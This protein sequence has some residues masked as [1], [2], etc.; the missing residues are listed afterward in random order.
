VVDLGGGTGGL[1]VELALQGAEVT[2]IDPSPDALAAL[3]RRAAEKGVTRGVHA[4]Q[5]DAECLSDLVRPASIDLVM[6]HRTLA[7]GGD[8]ARVLEAV[9][10]SLAPM[11]ALSLVAPQLSG[12]LLAHVVAG[13]PAR[14][15][16][17]LEGGDP[18]HYFELP[19][20]TAL[21]NSSGLQIEFSQGLRI[22]SELGGAMP[23]GA[24]PDPATARLLETLEERCLEREPYRSIAPLL[25]V[26]GRRV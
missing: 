18:A 13:E 24:L 14:A 5:G 10:L 6:C 22:F 8:L 26:W 1:A 17:L 12:A 2:V 4:L 9:A 19:Q 23:S 21:M 11:G 15:L 20:I 7:A 3:A 16:A 25:H